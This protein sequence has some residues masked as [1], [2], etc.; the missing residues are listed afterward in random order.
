MVAAMMGNYFYH[1]SD[2]K[3]DL[4]DKFGEARNNRILVNIDDF[5]VGDMKLNNDPFKS[6]ITGKT[7]GYEAKGKT[8][9]TIRNNT[10]YVIT[11]NN[12]GPVK[13]ETDDRR[14][15]LLECSKELVGNHLY[16]DRLWAY[17]A[18]PNNIKALYEYF[19]T[20]DTSKIDLKRDRPMNEL[21]ASLKLQSQSKENLFLAEFVTG[22]QFKPEVAGKDYYE[23]YCDW[24][25]DNG[26]NEYRPKDN[27]AIGRLLRDYDG[28]KA[29]RTSSGMKYLFDKDRILKSLN[30]LGIVSRGVCLF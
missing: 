12:R 25:R 26:F 20:Y 1:T 22:S 4:F 28:F 15:A 30:T 3:T 23:R 7:I 17:V 18:D 27:L 6:F 11:T 5:N 13:V 16:F 21:Y 2:P 9:L 24:I 8:K 19:L 29:S 10:N 14:Y